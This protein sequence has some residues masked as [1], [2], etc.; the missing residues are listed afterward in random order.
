M[1][2]PTKME[3]AAGGTGLDKLC[4]RC[5]LDQGRQQVKSWI[6]DVEFRKE[7]STRGKKI[8]SCQHIDS[9]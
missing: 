9:I 3:K 6:Y 5:L 8:M 1:E 7:I 2:S 4:L